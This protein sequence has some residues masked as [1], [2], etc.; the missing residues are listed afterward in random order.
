MRHG[1]S[2]I[3]VKPAVGIN[4]NGT[5]RS[6]PDDPALAQHLLRLLN[7]GDALVQPFV[8]AILSTGEVSLVFL[9]SRYSHA[10]RKLPR[11][12]DFRVQDNHGG[13]VQ[14]Y[15]PSAKE[16]ETAL[17][18]LAVAPAPTTYARVDVV[19]LH[20]TPAVMELELIEP[21]LFL[22]F[23]PTAVETLAR[24][25]VFDLDRQSHY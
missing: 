22:R 20:G 2:E 15:A 19:D 3:V 4:S 10:V 13:S 23:Y 17:A 6:A 21:E 5:M 18:A 7:T 8:P 14:P 24:R 16:I 12:G 25:L 1:S 11:D 9:G